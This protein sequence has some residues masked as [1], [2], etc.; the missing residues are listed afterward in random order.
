MTTKFVPLLTLAL[1][2]AGLSSLAAAQGLGR[3]TL[4]SPVVDWP[5]ADADSM[6][7]NLEALAEHAAVCDSSRASACIVAYQGY[8]VQEWY[9]DSYPSDPVPMQPWIGL[10]SATKSVAGLLA[11]ILIDDGAIDSVD[12]PVSTFIPEWEAGDSAGVTLRHLLTMTSGVAKHSGSGPRAGVVAVK[13]TTDYVLGLPLA[14]SPG[15]KWN[16][17]NEGAQLL[18]PVLERAAGMSL[19]AFA[20][21]RLLDPLGMTTSI[22]LIDE[23]YNTVTIGGMRS[24]IREFA[25][26]GQLLANDGMWN[27]NS[28]VSSDWLDQMTTPVEQNPYYGFLWWLHTD[29]GAVSA[30]GQFDQIIYVF[31]ERDL[32]AVR[33]Q[34]DVETGKTGIYWNEEVT[35]LLQRIVNVADTD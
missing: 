4:D 34:R 27:G 20:R 28:I 22:M 10:R 8:I 12:I 24:R 19:A 6:G 29:A 7:L 32:I 15:E 16:Y 2:L 11:G 25:R 17:S 5:V 1:L 35:S 18:S 3:G 13:N 31:P 26:L 30:A 9:S 21:E 33:L 23:Y 14:S